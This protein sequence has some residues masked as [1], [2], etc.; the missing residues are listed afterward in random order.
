MVEGGKC[1]KEKNKAR[2]GGFIYSHSAFILSIIMVFSLIHYTSVGLLHHA[3]NCTHEGLGMGLWVECSISP[4]VDKLTLIFWLWLNHF[5]YV[6][7]FTTRAENP[8]GQGPVLY[9]SLT[10]SWAFVKHQ[11]LIQSWWS[12]HAGANLWG[13][14]D[15]GGCDRQQIEFWLAKKDSGAVGS[16]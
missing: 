4:G 7:V 5:V 3:I 13:K 2:K 6:F 11:V 8:Q 16:I 10:F 12:I 14:K 15:A 1:S 9:T